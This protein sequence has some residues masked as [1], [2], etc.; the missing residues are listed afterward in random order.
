MLA[1]FNPGMYDVHM[2]TGNKSRKYVING[3]I[4]RSLDQKDL[5]KHILLT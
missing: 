1:D 2:E 4:V 5:R 3:G